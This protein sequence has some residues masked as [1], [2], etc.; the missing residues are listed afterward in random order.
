MP[1]APLPAAAPSK[2]RI[3]ISICRPA[4][5]PAP[6]IF[7]TS[8]ITALRDEVPSCATRPDE[9]TIRPVGL[10]LRGGRAY[11][12]QPD[13]N[14]RRLVHILGSNEIRREHHA[15]ADFELPDLA[16]NGFN[17]ADAVRV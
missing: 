3:T 11:R 10:Q 13:Q 7:S 8:I 5:P 4:R 14:L 6:L 15:L 16:T 2:S 12:S 1:A 9:R 17:D